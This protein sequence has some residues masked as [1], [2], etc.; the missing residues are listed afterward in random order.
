VTVPD[1][2][3]PLVSDEHQ[4]EL[5]L[6]PAL[7]PSLTL[8]DVDQARMQ[9]GGF[10]L[11]S[12]LQPENSW[13]VIL[14]RDGDH[15]WFQESAAGLSV[16]T[17]KPGRDGQTILYTQNDRKQVADLAG[18][19]R[20]DLDGEVISVTRNLMGHHDFVELP[21]GSIAWLSLELR[22][23]TVDQTDFLVAGDLI[24]EAP[25]GI[26]EG[27]EPAIIFNFFDDYF[28]P[29]VTCTHF[30]DDAY[31]TGGK[32]WSHCNSLMYDE[33]D[34]TYLVM[35]RNFDNLIKI[36]RSNGEILWE[37]GG[38]HATV[39]LPPE[40]AWHHGHMSH[41][42]D[43]GMV[44]FDNGYHLDPPHSRIAEYTFD[45]DAG[46]AELVWDYWDPEGR[47]IPLL[48]DARRLPGGNTLACWTSAGMMTEL[49]PDGDVVWRLEG[50]I[51]TGM[52]R[53]TW[54]EDIYDLR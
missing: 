40:D 34:D 30:L 39:E 11:T 6:P 23:V 29:W 8:S 2:G 47:F 27:V 42:W 52:G 46:S 51:G 15:V 32:D 36:D 28:D 7:L 13:V 54:I 35:C 26:E 12:Y 44:I 48:G 50:A 43:G 37:I 25:E 45:I 21:D 16:P 14:D 19:V 20:V 17:A 5:A 33:A 41:L 22:D 31:G 18:T 1:G 38:V 24:L 3:E 4:V 49:T 10:V 9:P 53:I